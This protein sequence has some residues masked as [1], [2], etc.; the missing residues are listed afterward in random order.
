MRRKGET[1]MANYWDRR[2][3]NRISRRRLL[4]LAGGGLSAALVT[5]ACGGDDDE[6]QD[7]PAAS[8]AGPS[9]AP[10]RGGIFVMANFS[11]APL[12]DFQDV[13]SV[14]GLW[15]TGV[16]TAYNGLTRIKI[17]DGFFPE[18]VVVEGALADSW[19]TPDPLTF[20]IHLRKGIKFHNIAP[21]NGRELVAEDV[22]YSYNRQRAL[23][24]N[25]GPLKA[26]RSYNAIDPYTLRLEISEPDGEFF[27]FQLS[28]ER[29][30]VVSHE[31]VKA[32]GDKLD[33]GPTIGTS[34]W[35][36][37]DFGGKES[38]EWSRNPNYFLPEKPYLDGFKIT[39]I[40]DVQTA[41]Q[42]FLT[43]KIYGWMA[44]IQ[45]LD[46]VKQAGGNEVEVVLLE[47]PGKTYGVWL[48]PA[49][50]ITADVRVRQAFSKGFDRKALM[51]TTAPK[52]SPGALTGGIYT[53]DTSY[54]LPNSESET[55]YKYDP[56]AAK[57]LLSAA[58]QTSINSELLFYLEPQAQ[59]MT[60]FM[61]AQLAEIGM[62]FTLKGVEPVGLNQLWAGGNF[63]ALSSLRPSIAAGTTGDLNFWFK[64]RAAFNGLNVGNAKIDGL[65]DQQA[66]L[67][68]KPAD[69][70]KV[71]HDLQREL[72]QYAAYVPITRRPAVEMLWSFVGTAGKAR[73]AGMTQRGIGHQ[74]E[75]VWLDA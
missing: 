15:P 35:V 56:Q 71:L 1:E 41:E 14:A 57:Q 34:A 50:G 18:R 43:K 53:Y 60:E 33:H 19:E 48:N 12:E 29:N 7:E 31:A 44:P 36:L 73:L 65:I 67:V 72:I 74:Y 26:L 5:A 54:E 3:A 47:N 39:R 32:G 70:A 9:G 11:T 64:T 8:G 2:I 68:D 25:A 40:A 42:A 75:D 22:V 46:P 49:S 69:R 59:E 30:V 13:H 63:S 37:K 55:I 16:G 45:R 24:V 21:T 27:D 58:G 6:D 17:G 20:I 52:S 38:I 10:K 61:V 51:Q 62:K 28:D 4:S 66:K 23:E